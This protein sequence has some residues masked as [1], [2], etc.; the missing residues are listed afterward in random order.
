MNYLWPLQQ[1]ACNRS[2][3]V[4][5]VSIDRVNGSSVSRGACTAATGAEA[6]A[7]VPSGDEKAGTIELDR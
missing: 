3:A 6:A 7:P 4:D 2:A 1:G 5:C